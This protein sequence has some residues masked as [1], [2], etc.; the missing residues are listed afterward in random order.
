MESSTLREQLRAVA[1]R[2]NNGEGEA[3]AVL[4][5][6]SQAGY[7]QQGVPRA[8][9][10]S[11]TRLW[12][13]V[14]AI[15]EVSEEC[16]TSGFLFWCQRV[17]IEYLLHTP[18]SSLRD[19]LLPDML[20]ANRAGATGLSNAM[21]HLGGLEPLR[22]QATLSDGEVVLDGFLP[23]ASNLQPGRFVVAVA[24]QVDEQRAL[25][26]AV[27]AE[28]EGV[29]RS[30][31]LQLL[32]LQ[33]SQ[34]ATVTL[35]HVRLSRQWLLA[36][37]A[38]AFLARVR[39]RF[40]LLQCGLPMG[41][42]RRAL[43]EATAK[44]QSAKRVLQERADD[45][46]QQWQR[47]QEQT[48]QFAQQ[49]QVTSETLPALFQTRIRWVRLAVQ[50]V[51]LEIEATGGAGFLRESDTARRWREV[52]FLPVLTPSATQLALQLQQAGWTE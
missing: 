2:M 48:R 3:R 42:A 26:A 1:H 7:L 39:P 11:G 25:V 16:L 6:L 22:T 12:E 32:G 45:L 24:A 52:A 49:E 4:G 31:D 10:G 34:T 36:E 9:G 17:F 28:A 37:D 19:L 5:W 40:L 29:Q 21:K 20:S 51:G 50:A 18:N 14:Q 41:L 46:C 47:L 44:M 27:P 8:H 38:H 13:A 33:S 30:E 15:A 43:Q 23:W 35:H